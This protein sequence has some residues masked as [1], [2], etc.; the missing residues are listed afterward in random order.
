MCV[1][2]C[3]RMRVR[4][5]QLSDLVCC[6]RQI[7]CV[8]VVLTQ[9]CSALKWSCVVSLSKTAASVRRAATHGRYIRSLTMRAVVPCVRLTVTYSRYNMVATESLGDTALTHSATR[10]HADLLVSRLIATSTIAY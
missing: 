8:H 1:G 4:V 10:S 9:G 5:S 6:R 7:P 3:V 2:E